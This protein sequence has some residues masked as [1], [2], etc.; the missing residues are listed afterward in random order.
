MQ[1]KCVPAPMEIVINNKSTYDDA[2]RSFADLI[3]NETKN[4]WIFYSMESIKVRENPGCLAALFGK[5]VKILE[6]NMLIF[7]KNKD[8]N[9]LLQNKILYEDE[10]NHE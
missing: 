2:V 6:Y 5:E 3:N 1:Y 9:K 4:G 10:F 7:S 8:E